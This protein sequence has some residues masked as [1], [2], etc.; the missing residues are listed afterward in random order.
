MAEYHF[1]TEWDIEA[2]IEAVWA[3]IVDT[4][5][6]PRWWR[7]VVDVTDVS[8]GDA[9]GVGAVQRFT[10]RSRLP[11]DLVFDIRTTV[12]DRPY[13][14]EGLASGELAGAG[15]WRFEARGPQATHVRYE[16]DVVTTKPWMNLLAPLL[17]PLFKWN[18][19]VIMGWGRQGLTRRLRER[20]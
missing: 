13:T 16:W 11:Y 1:V 6:W 8:P 4:P 19:D 20:T 12:V 3:I 9:H 15:R 7:G 18:H 17:R 5:R 14:L 2:P 10:W